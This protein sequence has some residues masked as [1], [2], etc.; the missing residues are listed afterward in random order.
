MTAND[1]SEFGIVDEIVP[2]PLGGAHVNP[3]EAAATL[4]EALERNLDDLVAIEPDD[5]VGKRREKYARMGRWEETEVEQ[6]AKM[7]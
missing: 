5:L 2:E 6:Q 4:G 3:D 7:E 1:L